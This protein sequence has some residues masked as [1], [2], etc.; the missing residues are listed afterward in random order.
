MSTSL[1]IT[2]KVNAGGTSIEQSN[3]FSQSDENFINVAASIADAQT[4]KLVVCSLDVSQIK[5]IFILSDQDLTLETNDG[6]T[7]DNTI[8]L[9]AGIPYVWYTNKYQ[10]LLLTV[11]VTALYLTNASGA[12]AAF[13]LV[14][15]LDAT[16]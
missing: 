15:L 7:P 2:E 16:P 9:K 13:K 8:A 6:T 11:D 14:A 5:A 12:A 3:T 4:D 10:V 1:V